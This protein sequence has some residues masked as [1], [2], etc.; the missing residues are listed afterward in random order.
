MKIVTGFNYLLGLRD[1][2]GHLGD[3]NINIIEV[4]G[5][6]ENTCWGK[7]KVPRNE[8]WYTLESQNLNLSFFYVEVYTLCCDTI[9]Y[10]YRLASHVCVSLQQ[11]L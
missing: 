3:I 10:L 6:E 9:T 7:T 2:V 4:Y 1:C 5:H 8:H 11:L